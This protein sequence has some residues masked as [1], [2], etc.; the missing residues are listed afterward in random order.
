MKEFTRKLKEKAFEIG[1][2]KI[3]IVRAEELKVEGEHLK[4]WLEKDFH[5][6]MKWLER[7]PEKRSDPNLLFP[8]ARSIVVVALNYF[9]P[10]EHEENPE[11][12]KVSRYAWGDDY[13]D[14]VKEKLRE[15]FALDK[16]G[17]DRKRTGKSALTPRR[18]WTRRGQFAP[19][20]AGSENIRT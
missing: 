2:H 16:I 15:L 4:Q 8:G 3:G 14:V 6:E 1:F 12:G 7:E 11:K 13:H 17:K 10:H 9:T 5:G 18:L 19:E 20:S